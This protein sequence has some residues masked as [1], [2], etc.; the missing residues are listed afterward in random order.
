MNKK[1]LTI[2]LSV[3]AGV[4]VLILVIALVIRSCNKKDVLVPTET[5]TTAEETTTT[6]ATTESETEPPITTEE[7]EVIIGPDDDIVKAQI[8][9][10]AGIP[11][12]VTQNDIKM[13]GHAIECRINAENPE[14]GFRPS[15]G[16]IRSLFIPGGFGVRVDTAVYQGYEIPPYYDSMIGKLIVY[17]RDRQEAIAKMTWALS[18][19]IV[20]GVST[21]VDFQLK[22]IRRPEFIE[23]NYDNAFLNRVDILKQRE[24]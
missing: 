20:E 12:H 21:N 8:E 2:T 4:L 13:R 14:Q 9:I 19:F 11:L 22:L 1:Q 6:E 24:E 18:E 5:T 23:G 7:G 3:I 16:T 15:P 10:A 17:G